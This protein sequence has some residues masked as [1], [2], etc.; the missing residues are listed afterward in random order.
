MKKITLVLTLFLGV[1]LL[2]SCSNGNKAGDSDKKGEEN[3]LRVAMSTDIDS[4][5][6]F[7]M[8]AGD[9]ETIMDQVFDGLFD[10]DTEGNLIPDLAES[11]S[12][13][14]DG[15]TYDF[16]LKKDVYFHDGK[17]FSAEDVLYTYDAMAGL[18]SKEPLSSKFSIIEKIDLVD[19]YH[20]RVHLK[21]RQNGFIYLTLRP[22]VEKDYKDNGTKPIGTGPYMFES[23]TPGEGL[24]LKKFEDYHDKDHIAHFE[25]VEVIKIADRQTMIMALKNNDLDLADR[26]SSEEASQLEDACNIN[27]FPQ[28]LVQVMG[29]NNDFKAFQDKNVRLALNYAID[30]DEIINTVAE[31]KATKLFSSFSPALK[32]YFEDLGEY[33]PYDPEKAKELLKEAGYE[34]GLTFKLTVPSDYKYHMNTAELIQAQLQKV[35]IETTIDPIEFSTWLTKVYKDRDYEATVVGFI[36]YLD[37][38]QI[39]GRYTSENPKNYINFKSSEFDQAISKAEKATTKEEEIQSIKDAQKVLAKDAASVF[40]ADPANNQALRKGLTGLNQYPI[41]KLNLEDVKL[42]KWVKWL[43]KSLYPFFLHCFL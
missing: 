7:K 19:D 42:E 8:T 17:E 27:S 25:N 6:P 29:L 4:L 26:I 28:N 35:G 31:G 10:V 2:A 32:E 9:T 15:K 1:L 34:N 18:T 41:Q 20:V 37:P 38:I 23:Y 21:E 16:K 24:R 5:D 11:Y 3:T 14:E 40:I 39:L 43:L 13:S 36:G 30:R 33:Y 22:I 12:V